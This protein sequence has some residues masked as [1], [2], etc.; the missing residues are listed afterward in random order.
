MTG[1]GKNLNDGERWGE[2][3]GGGGMGGGRGKGGDV[4]RL[5]PRGVKGQSAV[6]LPQ[7]F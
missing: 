4:Y 7:A 2:G 1:K 6:E 5:E 3:G